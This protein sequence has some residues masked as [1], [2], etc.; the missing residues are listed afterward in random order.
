MFFHKA[1]NALQTDSG[2]KDKLAP[3]DFGEAGRHTW[4]R[5]SALRLG[6]AIAQYR[7][8]KDNEELVGR[9]IAD[10]VLLEDIQ[11]ISLEESDTE[12]ESSPFIL[13][14]PD[15]YL[16]PQ[17]M[18]TLSFLETDTKFTFRWNAEESNIQMTRIVD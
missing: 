18:M 16:E 4:V 9:L 6:R 15:G 5:E 14:F 7:K 12:K 3:M 13:L 2:L 1:K 8:D 10:E 11:S 17:E